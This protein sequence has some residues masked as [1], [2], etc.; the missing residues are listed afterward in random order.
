MHRMM[1]MRG[2]FRNRGVSK[3]DH[4]D[5]EGNG[6][7]LQRTKQLRESARLTLSVMK[8]R[9]DTQVDGAVVKME[10]PQR[11]PQERGNRSDFYTFVCIVILFSACILVFHTPGSLS[12]V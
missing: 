1:A 5:G 9:Q 6:A 4:T 2:K 10:E 3:L 8:T 7:L 11:S 12:Q